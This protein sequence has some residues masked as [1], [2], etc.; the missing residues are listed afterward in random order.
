MNRFQTS[1]L[2]T[3]S[4]FVLILCHLTAAAAED[5]AE[6]DS[7]SGPSPT[8]DTI[9]SPMPS[10][11]DNAVAS[12]VGS[13]NAVPFDNLAANLPEAF[14]ALENQFSDEDFQ[15]MLTS[16]LGNPHAVEMFQSL[17]HDPNAINSISALLD[18][19][20]IQSSLSTEIEV[21]QHQ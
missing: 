2:L 11:E 15:A 1:L 19:P 4:V 3:L 20:K 7:S 6:V 17:I 21:K 9:P 14:S 8:V 18:D 13:G 16:Q 10:I 12:T 5:S